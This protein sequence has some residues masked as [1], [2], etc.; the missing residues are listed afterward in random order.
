M[1]VIIALSP[2]QSHVSI[3]HAET[4]KMWV[5]PGDRAKLS[6][7]GVAG[8]FTCSQ[9]NNYCTIS[10]HYVHPGYV[11]NARKLPCSQIRNALYYLLVDSGHHNVHK[12]TYII[13]C[14]TGAVA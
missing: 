6:P 7:Y 9:A 14:S 3:L 10:I 12:L 8:T 11:A 5:W 13:A 2:G 1:Q 4:L